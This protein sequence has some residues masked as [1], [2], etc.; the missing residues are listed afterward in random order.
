MVVNS[1]AVLAWAE[2]QVGGALAGGRGAVAHPASNNKT[3]AQ[4]EFKKRCDPIMLLILLEAALAGD[5]RL[6]RLVDDVRQA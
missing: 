1:T 3:N 2:T 4:L 5:P 6:H